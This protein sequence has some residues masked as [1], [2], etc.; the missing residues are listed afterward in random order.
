MPRRLRH[1]VAVTGGAGLGIAEAPGGKDHPIRRI[2]SP[3]GLYPGHSPVPD[4]QGFGPL[5]PAVHTGLPHISLQGRHH[6]PG[7]VRHREYPV[8]PFGLQGHAHGLK[9]RFCLL[10]RKGVHNGVQESGVP[11]HVLQYRP[12]RAVIGHIAAALAGDGEL[13]AEALRLFQ[14]QHPR[15]R[16]SGG[17]R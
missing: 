8:S 3:G 11:G 10:G 4:Q 2:F 7:T 12:R 6:V 5:I 1:P 17:S 14:Q 13:P 15:A 16:K 9:G